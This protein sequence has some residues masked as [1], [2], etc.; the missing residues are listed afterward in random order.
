[1]IL[2]WT[3]IEKLLLLFIRMILTLKNATNL[4]ENKYDLNFHIYLAT[5]KLT[6]QG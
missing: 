4:L 5:K 2:K 3:K 1:M 6:L